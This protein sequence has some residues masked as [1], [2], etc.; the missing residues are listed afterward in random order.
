M[1]RAGTN[2]ETPGD[3][4]WLGTDTK[5]VRHVHV[6]GS[7]HLAAA[8]RVEIARLGVHRATDYHLPALFPPLVIACSDSD[9]DSSFQDPVHRLMEEYPPL[10]FASLAGRVIRVGP[11]IEPRAPSATHPES[12]GWTLTGS[13]IPIAEPEPER[14]YTSLFARIGALLVAAQALNFLLGARNQCVLDRVVELNPFIIESRT[15]RVLK[16]RQ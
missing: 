15:Y 3:R 13:A 5:V 8:T 10:L 7:G 11:L 14:P 2:N 4:T 16:V 12:R 6:F 9:D 1:T